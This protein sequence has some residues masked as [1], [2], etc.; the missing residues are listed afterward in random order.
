MTCFGWLDLE[1]LAEI[2]MDPGGAHDKWK[3]NVMQFN[4]KSD[5]NDKSDNIVIT[6]R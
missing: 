3:E 4:G 5:S 6:A 1:L 2:F